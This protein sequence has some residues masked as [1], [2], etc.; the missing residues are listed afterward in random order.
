VQTCTDVLLIVSILSVDAFPRRLRRCK[1]EHRMTF[2]DICDHATGE[3]LV[4][5]LIGLLRVKRLHSVAICVRMDG[6][7]WKE[8]NAMERHV[9][10]CE[11]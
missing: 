3:A 1:V 7:E 4:L 11:L 9:L 6:T 5:M 2:S 10:S 8:W